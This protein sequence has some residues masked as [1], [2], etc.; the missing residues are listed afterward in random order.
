MKKLALSIAT[1]AIFAMASFASAQNLVTY[2]ATGI[3]ANSNPTSLAATGIASNM[4]ATAMTLGNGDASNNAY[5]NSFGIYSPSNITTLAAAITANDYFSFT[6]TP[7]TGD[8]LTISTVNLSGYFGAQY[9][10]D[11]TFYLEA[12]VGSGFGSG[13]SNILAQWNGAATAA[14][15]PGVITLPTSG[16]QNVSG[17]VTFHIYV[18]EPHGYYQDVIGGGTSSQN[19]SVVVTGTV[20]SGAPPPSSGIATYN[21]TGIT[22]GANPTSL[23][24]TGV[25]SNL[26]ASA[27]TL[28]TSDAT[29]N[30]YP[31]SIGIYSPTNI[32]TLAAAITANN[33]FSFTLTPASGKTLNVSSLDL[34]GDFAAQ[35]YG[36]A[37]FYLEASTGSGFGSGSG[38]ILASWVPATTAGPGPGIVTMPTS[39]FQGL[40]GPV[41]FHIYV[42]EP[43]GYYQDV[44]GGGSSSANNSIV[45]NGSV[46]G[47]ST[48]PTITSSL[49]ASGTVGTAFSY[50]ITASGSPTSFNA[51][52]LPAGLSVSTT[53]GVISGTPTAASSTSAAI[54]ATNASGSGSATLVVTISAAGGGGSGNGI[55]NI[56]VNLTGD[57]FFADAIRQA[58]P[59]WDTLNTYGQDNNDSAATVDSQGWPTQDAGLIVWEGHGHNDGTYQ[60]S[61]NGK[62]T[63]AFNYGTI[64]GAASGTGTYN[65][66]TNTTTATVVITDTGSENAALLVSNTQRTSTSAT[67]T[68][69]TNVHLWRPVSE[70][71]SSSYAAGTLFTNDTIALSQYFS[72]T[73]FMDLLDVNNSTITAWSQRTLPS[74]WN[75]N[76]NNGD[77]SAKTAPNVTAKGIAYEFAVAYCNLTNTDLYLNVPVKAIQ[78]PNGN[79]Y[80]FTQLANLVKYGSDGTNPYT[81]TQTSPVYAGLKSTLHV[82]LEY[83]N[84]DWN[85]GFQQSWGTEGPN[86]NPEDIYNILTADQSA[87][88]T[89]WQII[90]YDG[91][92]VA[93]G[94][95]WN[96]NP[97]AWRFVALQAKRLSDAFRSVY[98]TSFSS[99][100]R[101][102]I[103]FQADNGNSTGSSELQ[104]MNDYYNNG[105]GV[106]HT[107]SPQPVNYYFWGAGGATYYNSGSYNSSGE[108]IASSVN[109]LFQSG[110]PQPQTSYITAYSTIVQT[111]TNIVKGYGLKRVAYEGGWGLSD[112]P[113][114]SADVSS[115]GIIAQAKADSRAQTSQFNSNQTFQTGGGDLN[116]FFTS[117]SWDPLDIWSLT[118]AVNNLTTPLFSAIKQI[119]TTAPATVT[120]GNAISGTSATT[121]AS[122]SQLFASNNYGFLIEQYGWVPLVST[123]R[124]YQITINLNSNMSGQKVA[125]FVDG[126]QIGT[127]V[128]SPASS[129][130]MGTVSLSAGQHGLVVEGQYTSNNSYNLGGGYNSLGSFSSVV[131]TPQ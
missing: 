80:Y 63:I 78:D 115:G 42:V 89:D 116:V 86:G 6:I 11:A 118:S 92:A 61:F 106:A 88:N 19:N 75:Q 97:A 57:W 117:T 126:K 7:N 34:S 26:T 4:T 83:G 74:V 69:I 100:V 121:L 23:A 29:N 131:L 27:M 55:A 123:A 125:V 56:G 104:F 49:S 103:E 43:H 91:G 64:N 101:P 45:V 54:S 79:M 14:P 52:G 70:G 62:A 81:S 73:R 67:G 94:G 58:R 87:N 122:G 60:L 110:V 102:L 66:S 5:S 113:A 96:L 18:V 17:P 50:Q 39:G 99:T 21:A 95:G 2:N 36:D 35:Y 85:N 109:A 8:N 47:G 38:N 108:D 93:S 12:S 129:V 10:G 48:A 3:A 16:F 76:D 111:D 22:Q 24:A 32:T 15:G 41:T 77:G 107:S 84:E 119:G 9:Y 33:Y 37:T 72:T 128:T 130:V 82:Y 46:T 13:T 124:N 114:Y 28:G 20:G 68:G 65:S 105:D 51:T 90:N 30:V 1:A 120:S 25:T 112:E 44:I 98:S 59:T 71:N 31:N 53:T 127:A 40:T